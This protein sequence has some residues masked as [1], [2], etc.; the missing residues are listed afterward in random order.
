MQALINAR[1]VIFEKKQN[2]LYYRM[3]KEYLQY[4]LKQVEERLGV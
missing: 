3:N 4:F 2:R 1:F